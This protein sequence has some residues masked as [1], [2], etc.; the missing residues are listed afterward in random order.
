MIIIFWLMLTNQKNALFE[1]RERMIKNQ[2]DTVHN[3]ISHYSNS[4]PGRQVFRG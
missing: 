1:D 4:G 3:L 2:I